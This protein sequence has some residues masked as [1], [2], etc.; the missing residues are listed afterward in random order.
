MME[1]TKVRERVYCLRFKSPYELAMAFF[2]Y[3]EFYESASPRLREKSFTWAEYMS[4]YVRSRKESAFG[5]PD[6]W[7]GFN[8]P[9]DVVRKVQA[10]GLRDPNHYDSLMDGVAGMIEAQE[11]GPS[12]LIGVP[13]GGDVDDH[14][15]AHALFYVSTDYRDGC[16]KA[17]EELPQELKEKLLQAMER[18]G[19][20]GKTALD[21]IQA[22]VST[23]EH[24]V[25]KPL[26]S[27]AMREFRK[28][29]RALHQKLSAK[30]T[31]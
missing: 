23:G 31:P 9:V 21:E 10:A 30:V 27:K 25:M 6:H 12:Y 3:Q 22:Y 17:F 8:I 18:A 15:L 2:R 13:E 26:R 16:R 20:P 14:E 19:Y 7:A 5:Y 4:W 24:A 11:D 28:T 1:L 29:I